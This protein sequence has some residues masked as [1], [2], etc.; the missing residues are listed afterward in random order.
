MILVID[1]R[2]EH[3]VALAQRLGVHGI[4]A[5]PSA[6]DWK[7]AVRCLTSH[8]ISLIVA[9]VDQAQ[10]SIEFFQTLKELTDVPMIAFGPGSDAESMVWYLDHG[11][12]DYVPAATPT[13]VFAA[14][15]LSRLRGEPQASGGEILELGEL[16][17]N[18]SAPVVTVG[19][20]SVA[21][22]PIE[23]RLLSTLAQNLGRTCSRQMLLEQ[24]WGRDFEDCAHYLR[25]YIGYL[26]QKIEAHPNRPQYLLTDW[27]S[28]YRLMAPRAKGRRRAASP[29]MR[30]AAS[31]G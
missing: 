24:V 14:K 8:P 23:F 22:T 28:G 11:A 19:A 9:G 20:R 21:L 13:S 17:I 1:Q 2:P 12:A 25:L 10:E 7:L 16:T 27:G 26:R 4:E 3:A 31:G 6:R 29:Q 18:L 30:P 5:I 15:L